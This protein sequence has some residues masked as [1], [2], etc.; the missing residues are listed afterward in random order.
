MPD[1]RVLVTGAGSGIGLEVVRALVSA[2]RPTVAAVQI[3]PQAT[4]LRHEFGSRV[5]VYVM[6]I[7]RDD[8]V[9]WVVDHAMPAAVLVNNAA[10]IHRGPLLDLPETRLRD[11]IEVNVLGTL[12]VTRRF[13]EAAQPL[14]HRPTAD[15]LTPPPIRV[16]NVSSMAGLYGVPLAGGYAATKHAMEAMTQALRTEL[17][18]A[19]VEFCTVNPGLVATGFDARAD[20]EMRRW[21]RPEQSMTG[22]MRVRAILGAMPEAASAEEVAEVILGVVE[23]ERPK[24]RTVVPAAIEDWLQHKQAEEW[25]AT[26]GGR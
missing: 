11:M 9:R 16:V 19:N 26:E 7:T 2:G 18:A 6:D 3:P 25:T 13:I 15:R 21:W 1:G 14:P 5:G 10:I 12:R 20:D 4:R 23:A 17:R 22:K 8:D 24:R